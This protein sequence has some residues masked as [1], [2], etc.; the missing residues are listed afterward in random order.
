MDFNKKTIFGLFDSSQ[1]Q[2]VIPVYQRAYSWEEKQLKMFLIDL[3][4]Q[5]ESESNYFYG[6]ILLETIEKDRKYEVIDGQQR[7]TTLSIFIR[8]LI[9]VLREKNV[10]QLGDGSTL[11][12]KEEDYIKNRGNIKLR[13]VEYDKNCYDTLIVEN[14]DGFTPNSPSQK[15]ILEAKKYFQNELRKLE[16]DV[17]LK[18]FEK[19][20]STELTTIE[21]KGKKDAALM[22]ELQNNRGKDLTNMEKLKSYFMYQMY[23]Y[24]DKEQVETNINRISDIF[25]SIYTTISDIK[26]EE[27]SVL[28]YHN[29]AFIKGFN[30]RTLDD[31]KEVFKKSENKVDW[32]IEYV[33]N[34]QTTFE[35][36][37]KFENN[38]SVSAHILKSIGLPAYAWAFIIRGYKYLENDKEKLDFL[39]DIL[40]KIIFR[41]KLINS[42]ANIQ[43]RLNE[44]LLSFEGDVIS[45]N[46]SVK[47]KLNWAGYWSDE[48]M[49]NTL[50][51]SMYGNNVLHHLLWEYEKSIQSKG[52]GILKVELDKEE[53][54]H[55]SPQKPQ[56]GRLATGYD[57]YDEDFEMNF[58]NCLG[59]LMLISKSHNASLGNKPFRHKLQSYKENPL[60]NQQAEIKDFCTEEKWTKKEIQE[61]HRKILDFCIKRWSF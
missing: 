21:L 36:I 13:P 48:T 18:I 22:F 5:I 14:Q 15:R 41:A 2:F 32:I 11:E 49:K 23:V 31:V 47:N 19:L 56:E 54:E 55:I 8:S 28:I 16:T 45:L 12:N 52:Y 6:N 38:P 42:R 46:E 29:N 59:N 50:N 7:L 37:K 61:R 57:K 60:L 30:Y 27:D 26:L 10:K 9:N 35:N 24:S 33:R 34:L 1:K 44:I 20:E 53:I 58:L 17:L 4:E 51:S 3:L 39:F 25:T 43:E 40:E